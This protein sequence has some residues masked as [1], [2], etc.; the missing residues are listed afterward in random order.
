MKQSD[1]LRLFVAVDVPAEHL[2]FLA[3]KTVPLKDKWPGKWTQIENQHITLKF[4]GWAEAS[5]LERIESVCS[6]AVADR[7]PISLALTDLG[8]FPSRRRMRV[9]WVGLDDPN[10][11]LVDLVKV[12]DHGFEPLGFEAEKRDF[13]PHLTLARFK[14]P[15]LLDEPL[16]DISTDELPRFEVEGLRLYRSHLSPK[17]ARYEVLREFPLG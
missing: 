15:I 12:L 17:G 5:S 13:T 14:M 9:L 6:G 11:A 1:R 2:R 10:R 8:S 16:P 3:D 4:L 7:A